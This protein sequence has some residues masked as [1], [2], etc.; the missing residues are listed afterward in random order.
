MTQT[1]GDDRWAANGF[2]AETGGRWLARG[3]DAAD[4]AAW[5]H[6]RIDPDAARAWER[7]GFAGGDLPSRAA[8]LGRVA[9]TRARR[10][11][12]VHAQ[13]DATDPA[14]CADGSRP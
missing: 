1:T 13:G 14:R 6:H 3:F 4:A 2:D 9:A 5:A 11:A 8:Q 10:R 12:G 7:A